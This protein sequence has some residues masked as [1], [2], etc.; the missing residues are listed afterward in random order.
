MIG[1]SV[2]EARTRHDD[3]RFLSEARDLAVRIDRRPWPNPPVGAVVV[4]DGEVVGRGAHQG[5]GTAHAERVALDQA[6]AAARGATLYCTLEPCDHHG[7]TSPCTDAIL[8]AG[9]ARVVHG[10]ADPNPQAAGGAA[11]L[12]QAGVRVDGG[13]DAWACLDLIWPFVCTDQFA[14]PYVE[15]KTATTL[16]GR[17]GRTRDPL[18]QPTY[19]TGEPARRDVHARRRWVDLVLVGGGTAR[20][21]HPRLDV[22]LA[23]RPDDGPAEPP[24]AG[25]VARDHDADV[26]LVRDRW[27]AFGGPAAGD[28]ELPPGAEAITCAADALGR[29]DVADVLA[30]CAA[31]G[32]HTVMLEGGPRLAASFLDAGLVDRWVQYLAPLAVGAGPTWPAGAVVGDRRFH[33]S[34]CDRL[35]DDLRVIWDRRDFAAEVRRLGGQGEASCSPD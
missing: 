14:R 17:F 32:I 5:A 15:L 21:D 8:A 13:V 9:I 24:A 1:N 28:T 29:P 4:R 6:G 23:D 18:G 16:D 30:A 33:L 35:G 22:R 12:R 26:R 10:V 11:R 7:R 31:R 3:L 34:R 20:H 2:T 19:L 27:L 25:V